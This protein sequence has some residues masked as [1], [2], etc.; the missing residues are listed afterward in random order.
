MDAVFVAYETHESPIFDNFTILR[1][2]LAKREDRKLHYLGSHLVDYGSH[3][4]SLAK[5]EAGD[6]RFSS[7]YFYILVEHGGG[8]EV[9]QVRGPRA[10]ADAV[11]Q[12]PEDQAYSVLYAIYHTAKSASYQA[13]EVTAN[14]YAQAFIEGRLKKSRPKQGRCRVTIEPRSSQNNSVDKSTVLAIA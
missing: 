14:T 4:V 8:R 11:L 1:T 12:L 9:L 10:F 13:K 2:P 5:Y 6:F 3:E 7:G